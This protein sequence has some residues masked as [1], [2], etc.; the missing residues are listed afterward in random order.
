[1]WESYYLVSELS[2]DM[3]L[4]YLQGLL[5]KFYNLR[6]ENKSFEAYH[7]EFQNIVTKLEHREIKEHV[8]IHFKVGLNKEIY[9]KMTL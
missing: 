8:V 2:L 4:W 5:A 9:S 1:M 3:F 7:D 6:K